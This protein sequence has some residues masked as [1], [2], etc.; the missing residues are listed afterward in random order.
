MNV[1]LTLE[2]NSQPLRGGLVSAASPESA[3]RASDES[4]EDAL[5][6]ARRISAPTVGNA[7]SP[8]LAST[9]GGPGSPPPLPEGASYAHAS[10]WASAPNGGAGSALGMS[11]PA[12][13]G[14]GPALLSPGLP[15]ALPPRASA[16][17]RGEAAPALTPAPSAAAGALP[18]Q[19][20]SAGSELWSLMPMAMPVVESD[21]IWETFMA[22]LAR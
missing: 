11:L 10:L 22:G 16:S 20:P 4:K 3:R 14:M 18:A 2:R 12:A 9:N 21:A 19:P 1:L 15:L 7:Y 17:P 13:Q 6:E 5:P 8:S